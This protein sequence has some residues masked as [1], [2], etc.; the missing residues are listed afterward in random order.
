[1]TQA[2]VWSRT[3]YTGRVSMTGVWGTRFTF[4][5]IWRENKKFHK[6]KGTAFVTILDL[7]SLHGRGH[8]IFAIDTGYTDNYIP[9]VTSLLMYICGE[10]VQWRRHWCVFISAHGMTLNWAPW[11]P[12]LS[13][14]IK[15]AN[16]VSHGKENVSPMYSFLRWYFGGLLLLFFF[17]WAGVGGRGCLCIALPSS[18]LVITYVHAVHV[19]VKSTCTVVAITS[20]SWMTQTAVWPRTVYTGRVSMTGVWGT[21][22]TFI[23]I[24]RKNKKVHESKGT[25]FLAISDLR[26]LHSRRHLIFAIGTGLN[27]NY[28]L[29]VR[30]YRF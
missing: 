1:M 22:F 12:I 13:I 23:H 3:V 18:A 17:Y 6:S 2:A 10:H 29:V 14:S 28:I 24:W 5:H 11:V 25:A 15:C 26:S 27:D 4:I 30:N 7:R 8:L 9:V 16:F 20:V 19:Y 21:R